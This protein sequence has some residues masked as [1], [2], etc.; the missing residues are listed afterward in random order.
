[1]TT[2]APESSTSAAGGAVNVTD[3][4]PWTWAASDTISATIVYEAA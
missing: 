1:M 2:P 3:T 4:A